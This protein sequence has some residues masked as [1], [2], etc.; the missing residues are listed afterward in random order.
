MW[1]DTSFVL[2]RSRDSW[3]KAKHSRGHQDL[4]SIGQR[5]PGSCL[6]PCPRPMTLNFQTPYCLRVSKLSATPSSNVS[7]WPS[8]ITTS[9]RTRSVETSHGF[10]NQALQPF[11]FHIAALHSVLCNRSRQPLDLRAG[12]SKPQPKLLRFPGRLPTA[13]NT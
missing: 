10:R 12:L 11:A 1:R 2:S 3:P 7:R 9:I 8:S 6:Q 13:P 4:R 5:L